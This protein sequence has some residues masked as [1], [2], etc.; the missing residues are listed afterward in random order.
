MVYS[1]PS[2][3]TRETAAMLRRINCFQV[4]IGADSASNEM[5]RSLNTGKSTEAFWDAV[6]ILDGA[7]IKFS[8]SVIFGAPG[9]TEADVLSTLRLM[10][11]LA[12]RRNVFEVSAAMLIPLPGT[13]CYDAI[14]SH[15]GLRG[16]YAQTDLLDVNELQFDWVRHFCNVRYDLLLRAL[17]RVSSLF[18]VCSSFGR[19]VPADAE[20]R[21]AIS[22]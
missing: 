1:R 5:L 2:D 8:T 17:E 18:P 20:G 22:A 19:R 15:P 7:D 11:R 9:E 21:A 4:L 3:I 16:K 14:L 12:S 6:E 10:E 13:S